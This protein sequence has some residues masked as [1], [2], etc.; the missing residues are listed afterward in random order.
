MVKTQKPVLLGLIGAAHGT[1][2]EVRIKTFTGD[3]LALNDYG[4][5]FDATGRIYKILSLRAQKNVVV[6]RLEGIDNRSAAESLNGTELFIDR[7]QLPDILEEDEFYQ[8][9]LIGLDAYDENG[10]LIGK[11][12]ALFN[13]GGG[14][15]IEISVRNGKNPFIPFS[16]AAV[17]MIDLEGRRI[18]VDCAAAGMLD[19]ADEEDEKEQEGQQ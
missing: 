2:G 18:T 14:D 6:A 9:D 4:S 13:F 19:D 11:V 7:S 1:R 3:P 8:D 15:L 17:P 10:E 5:I 12:R 16:K